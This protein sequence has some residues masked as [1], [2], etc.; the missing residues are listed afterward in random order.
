[1]LVR[2]YIGE[3]FGHLTLGIH[4]EGVPGA[5]FYQA[6]VGQRGWSTSR[7]PMSAEHFLLGG[8]PLSDSEKVLRKGEKGREMRLFRVLD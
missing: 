6:E 8:K 3:H 1:M 7:A 5:E 2:I 4:D